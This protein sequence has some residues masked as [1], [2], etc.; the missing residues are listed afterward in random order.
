M[1]SVYLIGLCWLWG[2]LT[3]SYELHGL[4][5]CEDVSMHAVNALARKDAQTSSWI[6]CGIASDSYASVHL[7]DAIVR[8]SNGLCLTQHEALYC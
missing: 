7:I 8:V 6:A 4:N 2:G 5:F 1:Q 3:L